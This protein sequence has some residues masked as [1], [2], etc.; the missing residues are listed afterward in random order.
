VKATEVLHSRQLKR[1]SCR[2][3]IIDVMMAA[4]KALSETEI[5][6]RLAGK[7]DR[8]TF[9]RSF[10]TLE[11]NHI[12]HKIVIENQLIKYSL[13]NSVTHKNEHAHFFCN[14]CHTV[15]CLDSKIVQDVELPDG[16]TVIEKAIL[17]KG[18]CPD[19]QNKRLRN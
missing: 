19:C 3:G 1:T 15:I 16:Y 8:T 4:G 7:Y 17:I 2:E 6:D 9:Y 14:D 12:I 13:D 10:K 11:E 18:T 5:R